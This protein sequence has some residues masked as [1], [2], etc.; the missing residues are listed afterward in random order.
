MKKNIA[1]IGGGASALVLACELDPEKFNVSL[2]EKNAALGRKFLVAGDGGLNF[3]HSEE[4]K[5]FLKRYSPPHFL[6]KAFYQA[7]NDTYIKWM[8]A[9]G[10]ETF[11]GSSGRL[12]PKK[13]IKPIQVLD[14]IIEKLKH[15]GVTIFLKHTWKGFT[16]NGFLLFETPHQSMEVHADH[17]VFCLGGATWPVTGSDGKWTSYFLKKN[18]KVLNFQS[19]NC[20]FK[21][22]WPQDLLSKIEGKT[23][24]NCTFSCGTKIH[25]GE[26]V[27]TKFGIEGSGIY[28][29]S[30]EIRQ[31]LTLSG[32]MEI[33]VDFKPSLTVEKIVSKLTHNPASKN[34]STRL[35]LDLNLS[36]TQIVLLKHTLSKDEFLD[37][38][39]LAKHIKSFTLKLTGLA[40]L[41]EAI[42]SVGGISLD[43]MD[44]N[45]ELIK[46][47]GKFVIGEMLDYDA[48]T[49]GYLLQSCFSMAK[50]LATHLNTVS[51]KTG[52]QNM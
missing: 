42:S 23:L 24:K 47:K 44:E 29:L 14:K 46:L 10:I 39:L 36:E 19:S 12:F 49:G 28:P 25:K 16:E 1:I 27:L 31:G 8:N 30:P 4:P 22:N 52:S 17:Y 34:L 41:D 43:E 15:K 37:L 40:P 51:S 38:T 26:I 13:G 50:T 32:K 33:Q 35:K 7:S 18:I 5:E 48:P 6:E 2:Y 11:V 3:T 45:F 21:I 9:L 20:A